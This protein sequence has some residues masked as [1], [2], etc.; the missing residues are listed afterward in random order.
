VLLGGY[1][2]LLLYSM[3]Q[4]FVI[5][6]QATATLLAVFCALAVQSGAENV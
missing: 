6:D 2:G 3:T 5:A 4:T 1:S